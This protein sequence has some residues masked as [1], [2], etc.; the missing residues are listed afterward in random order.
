M[1]SPNAL[2]TLK[3]VEKDYESGAG[4]VRALRDVQLEI[5]QGEFVAIVGT[6]GSGKSTLM[7]ILGCLDRPTRGVYE[8]SGF[9]VGARSSDARAVLRNR[10]IG[11]IFQ[12]F[13]L[14]PRTTALENVELPLVY[15]GV[16]A[17]QR[18]KMAMEA[19][20]AVGLGGRVHHT[21]NQLSGG[22]QQRVAIA[23][24]LVTGPPMLLADEP[25]GNLDTRTSLEV[26]AL[27]QRLN[28]ERGITIV[29]VTHE[30]DIASCASRVVTF[31]DG[32]V[33]SDAVAEVPI[34]AAAELEKLPP[35]ETSTLGHDDEADDPVV[36][37]RRRMGGPVPAMAYVSMAI[38]GVLGAILGSIYT[39]KILTIPTPIPPVAFAFFFEAIAAAWYAGK[40]LG[41][42]FTIDQRARLSLFYTLGVAGVFAPLLALGVLPGSKGLLDRL[43]ELS[44]RGVVGALF[45]VALGLATM[46]LARFLVI[47][48]VTP[49][50]S[51]RSRSTA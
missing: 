45:V 21:P 37:A 26:L 24:A 41:R 16:S 51:P 2:I 10:L 46:A 29:L 33:V 5:K 48:L 15:R 17:G 44:P 40:K 39:S 27:L 23:R 42:P 7:N 22:Q 9:D 34:N 1:S 50:V 3:H 4:V 20:S 11:F 30:H 25:T 8:L 13:N 32:R 14:L 38:A 31:R 43:A 47:A 49:L 18:R 35:A 6:S 19:L 36:A 28:R 12:G